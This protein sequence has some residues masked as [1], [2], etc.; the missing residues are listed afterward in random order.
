MSLDEMG[1][2]Q[3]GFILDDLR[4]RN[5]PEEVKA[6]G[7]VSCTST[8]Y[9]S[10]HYIC[11][12]FLEKIGLEHPAIYVGGLADGAIGVVNAL[13]GNYVYFVKAPRILPF[14]VRKT[15][16]GK[17]FVERCFGEQPAPDKDHPVIIVDDVLTSG[18]SVAKA[19]AA[20]NREWGYKP[21]LAVVLVDN[22]M[23]GKE[24]LLKKHGIECR[25]IF[26]RK[27]ILG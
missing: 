17:Q 11:E 22:E 9:D 16:K 20:I 5:T 18:Y 3:R 1:E 27:E 7:Y 15:E 24:F 21:T 10:N 23:G 26:T 13:Y 6:R 19:A 8:V 4:T 12:L 25:S 2:R 14:F